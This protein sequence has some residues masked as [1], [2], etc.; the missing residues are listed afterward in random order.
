MKRIEVRLICS[1]IAVLCVVNSNAAQEQARSAR[2]QEQINYALYRAIKVL[3]VQKVENLL[4]ENANANEIY[5]GSPVIFAAVRRLGDAW[6]APSLTSADFDKIAAII[7]ALHKHGADINAADDIFKRTPLMYSVYL[8]NNP[9]T[10]LLIDL[11]AKLDLKDKDGDTVLH[12]VVNNDNVDALTV[13]M[14]ALESKHLLNSM[15]NERNLLEG[16]TPLNLATRR[17]NIACV[18]AL[19]GKHANPF[20]KNT[21]GGDALAV[22]GIQA[23]KPEL[24]Q[25]IEEYMQTYGEQK[26]SKKTDE[27]QQELANALD[28]ALSG[29]ALSWQKNAELVQLNAALKEYYEYRLGL[30]KELAETQ[31]KGKAFQYLLMMVDKVNIK[32]ENALKKKLSNYREMQKEADSVRSYLKSHPTIKGSMEESHLETIAQKLTVQSLIEQTEKELHE[33]REKVLYD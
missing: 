2:E 4:N 3:D 9:I 16:M 33:F 14:N 25:M 22:A 5:E 19:I 18:K 31:N 26:E 13:I 17:G 23:G 1:F 8:K 6:A 20:I 11:G 29:S 15:L 21:Y 12:L 28:K 7:K 32:I 27:R 30:E 24:K 10:K